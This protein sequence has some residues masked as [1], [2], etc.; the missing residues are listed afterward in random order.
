MGQN[1]VAFMQLLS[2][3]LGMDFQGIMMM[4]RREAGGLWLLFQQSQEG[5]GG[6]VL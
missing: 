6:R 3:E 5:S 1:D 2:C 4:I